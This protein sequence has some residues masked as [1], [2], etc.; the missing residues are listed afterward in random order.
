MKD[1]AYRTTFSFLI[2]ATIHRSLKD[3]AKK[4]KTTM[5]KLLRE[6]I[7]MKLRDINS[8]NGT[9]ELMEEELKDEGT[10]K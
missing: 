3:A 4:D 7:D 1:K 9:I 5:S 2:D 8:Q 6:A 10:G